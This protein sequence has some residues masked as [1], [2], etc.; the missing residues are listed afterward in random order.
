M[1]T[2]TTPQCKWI[3]KKFLVR[4][5]S[6]INNR[7]INYTDFSNPRSNPN[8]FNTVYITIQKRYERAR[9]VH[10][11]ELIHSDTQETR[12]F[13]SRRNPAR[14]VSIRTRTT[15][16]RARRKLSHLI[17]FVHYST[18]V[19][20]FHAEKFP[21]QIKEPVVYNFPVVVDFVLRIRD[22]FWTNE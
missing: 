20:V 22:I 14:H 10:T 21:R 6:E 7:R 4:D 12:E 1:C 3:I 15:P 16:P 5:F 9:A 2:I 11:L 19:F 17:A 8:L 13:L 18:V